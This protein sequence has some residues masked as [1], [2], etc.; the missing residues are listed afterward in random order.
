M[1]SKLKIA[2]ELGET[3]LHGRYVKRREINMGTGIFHTR[4]IIA[5]QLLLV[6]EKLRR[7]GKKQG[8]RGA[9]SLGKG[10]CVPRAD[11]NETR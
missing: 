5:A 4:G 9:G 8:S 3:A 7:R 2:P 11:Q 6:K 1:S 10:W